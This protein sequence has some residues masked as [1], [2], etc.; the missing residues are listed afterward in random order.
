MRIMRMLTT[1]AS[2]PR[3]SAASM[4]L[5]MI[6]IVWAAPVD[7][8]GMWSEKAPMPT[9][10]VF[11]QG[12]VINGRL[13]VAGGALPTHTNI[14]ESYDPSTDTWRTEPPLGDIRMLG[15]SA[16]IGSQ[17]YIAAGVTCDTCQATVS[18][19]IVYDVTTGTSMLKNPLPVAAVGAM[20][21]SVG[22]IFYVA[23]GAADCCS[24]AYDSLWA[25]NPVSDTWTSRA[26]MPTGRNNGTAAVVNGKIYV[27]GGNPP[28]PPVNAVEVYD[29]VTDTWFS[30]APLP[31]GRSLHSAVVVNGKIIVMGG[32]TTQNS[33]EASVLVYDPSTD[34][35]TS[36]TP[37][38]TPRQSMVA[39]VIASAAF[40]V[41]G[42]CCVTTQITATNEAF[43]PGATPVSF[44]AYLHGS[45]S[46]LFLNGTSPTATTPQFRDSPSLTLGGGNPWREIGIWSAA[47]SFSSGELDSLSP[48][49]AWLGLKNSDDQ[50]TRF[51]L[52]AE[53]LK[54]GTLVASG[55]TFCITGV[56]RNPSLAL[57]V[58]DAYNPFTPVNFNG[59]TDVL[60]LRV[61]TRIGTNG[62]G[63]FCGGHSNA[64][65]LRLYFDAVSRPSRFDGTFTE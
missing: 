47:P 36:D 6:L 40:A 2:A 29:P 33:F 46:T 24:P 28:G 50:G 58:I 49:H 3:A 60:S 11:A 38:P 61:L 10:R 54:N 48:L 13:Y 62:A 7:G 64:T 22:G 52:R 4:L 20:G 59:S 63:A 19:T 32:S 34:T 45:G 27:I 18:P 41:G 21:A 35:W 53:V 55:E 25:Y 14:V 51:D 23:G 37:I 65:G 1:T 8:Q 57:E 26:P 15:A 12:G 31:Q 9:P 43:T 56:T 16:A 17:L 44:T 5:T 42:Y 39:D 30:A